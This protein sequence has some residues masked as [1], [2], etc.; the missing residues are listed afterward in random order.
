M[1]TLQNVAKKASLFKAGVRG[2][3]W[4]R[5]AVVFIIELK[6]SKDPIKS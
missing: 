2:G 3:G 5:L 6:Y 1:S 4:G